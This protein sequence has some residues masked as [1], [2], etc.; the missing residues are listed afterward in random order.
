[1]TANQFEQFPLL[2]ALLNELERQKPGITLNDRQFAA[3][4]R[5]ADAVIAAISVESPPLDSAA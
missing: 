1:M 2:I 5:A 3:I 4:I